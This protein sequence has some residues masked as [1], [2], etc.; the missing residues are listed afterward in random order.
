MTYHILLDIET[1]GLRPGC[2]IV[3]LGAV[4]FSPEGGEPLAEFFREITPCPHLRVEEVTLRWHEKRGSW[5]LPADGREMALPQALADF[6]GWVRGLAA[7]S[8][9]E[10]GSFWSWGSTYDFPL[11]DAAREAS[12]AA[13]IPC[14]ELPWDYWQTCCA[15]TMWR[16][17]FGKKRTELRP[18][19]ALK[20]AH[21]AVRDL[22]TALRHLRSARTP[23][24]APFVS[25]KSPN[26]HLPRHENAR[27][28]L[29]ETSLPLPAAAGRAATVHAP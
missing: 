13:G 22:T 9:G 27:P 5:P 8:G 28:P 14:P 19:H 18:H 4:A 1:L 20:D 2:A 21:A 10:I 26:L 17:A 23:S 16:L 11:L 15:R 29:I 3:Q 6:S 12:L 25:L 7:K 24:P